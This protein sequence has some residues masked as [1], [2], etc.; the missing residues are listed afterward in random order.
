M[1][2][3]T[4]FIIFVTTIFPNVLMDSDANLEHEF[5]F[6]RL[7][8]KGKLTQLSNWEVDYPASDVNFIYQLQKQTSIDVA[9]YSKKI[10][11]WS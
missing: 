10:Q 11:V 7:K 6:V 8:Y 4:A 5:T 1:R 9:P 2:I 3:T